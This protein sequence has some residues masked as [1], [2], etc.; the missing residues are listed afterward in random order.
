MNERDQQRSLVSAGFESL[1]K[2][3]E[4]LRDHPDWIHCKDG[5]GETALHFRVIESQ[6]AAVQFLDKAGSNIGEPG[7]FGATPLMNA[8]MRAYLIQ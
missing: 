4:S 8:V 3:R 2:A 5:V 6:R 7:K 1:E